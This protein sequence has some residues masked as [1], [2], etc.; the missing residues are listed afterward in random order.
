MPIYDEPTKVLMNEFAKAELSPGQ[1]F[2]KS[3]PVDWFAKHYPKIKPTTVQ[4]HVE[5]MSV[6][7]TLRRHHP[8]IHAGSGHDLFW[9]V[10]PKQFRLWDPK[11]DPKPVYGD[12]KPKTPI[13]DEALERAESE[14]EASEA[15]S[16]EFA[17]ER[18]LRNYLE[19][20]LNALELGLK[21]YEEEG[22][23]GVE[24]PV[25]GRR[26]D[27]LGIGKD[28]AFVVIELKVSRGY[29]R[30]VG[31]IMRYMAWIKKNLADGKPVRGIIVAS[32]ISEDLRMAT[33]MISGV[34]LVEYELSF[35]LK[36]IE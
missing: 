31:Q 35:K 36:P 3:M 32:E 7:S 26:I 25:G 20:N 33:S 6:N 18:D 8:S 23:S 28:G 16:T 27:I 34:Q 10:G 29:D 24:F 2:S 21:L 17:A 14:S 22:L 1:V 12:E 13:E 4:M 9:K 19:K 30:V 5:G 11:I 15:A